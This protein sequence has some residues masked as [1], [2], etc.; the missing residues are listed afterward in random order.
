MSEKRIE[1][2]RCPKCGMEHE[3]TVWNRINT[4]LDPD[5]R[6]KVKSGELFRTACPS[7]G[8]L[9]DV[10]YPC[11]YHQM[12][13]KIMIYY[14][15]GEEAMKMASEAFR[16]GTEEIRAGQG[17]DSEMKEYTCRVVGSLYDLQEKIA[18]FDAGLDDRVI[19]ICKIFIGS[20]LQ[21]S[22]KAVNF[23]DL[24]Y[25]R[26]PEGSDRIALMREGSAFASVALPADMY[27]MIK[28]RYTALIDRCGG[29]TVI[30][31]NWVLKS[32]SEEEKK[33]Q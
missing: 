7:C 15:P 5:L 11:L 26:A 27:A 19:E 28:D 21:D 29:E 31:M 14:A 6:D 18:V 12:E 32:V 13:D 9:I 10:V 16:E 3:F 17:E 30:D 22:Q 24:R 8:Q 1:K 25:Y 20:E 4:A 2:I 33:L 23:D